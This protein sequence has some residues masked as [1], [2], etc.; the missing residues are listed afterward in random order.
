M[1][2]FNKRKVDLSRAE[3]GLRHDMS[4]TNEV[5]L[6]FHVVESVKDDY[7]SPAQF[8]RKILFQE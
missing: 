8:W 3:V 1:Y 4:K 5:N 6:R 7:S 2:K